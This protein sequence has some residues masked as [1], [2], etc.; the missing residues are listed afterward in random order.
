MALEDDD[1]GSGGGGDGVNEAHINY[2]WHG[3]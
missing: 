3:N 1:I 2:G